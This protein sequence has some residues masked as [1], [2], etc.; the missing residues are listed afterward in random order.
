MK[1]LCITVAI[2]SGCTTHSNW[3]LNSISTGE[4]DFDSSRLIYAPEDSLSGFSLELDFF[5]SQIH[6]YLCSATHRLSMESKLLVE[7]PTRK[8]EIPLVVHEGQMRAQIP[9]D[10][11]IQAIQAL[12]DGQTITMIVGSQ[13][14]QFKPEQ[15]NNLFHQL[16]RKRNFLLESFQGS[17]P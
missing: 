6:G 13:K 3:Q 8:I 5:N 2:I 17:L 9:D 4:K 12:Q 10:V 14:Q 16:T 1:W 15:F 11:L 7:L